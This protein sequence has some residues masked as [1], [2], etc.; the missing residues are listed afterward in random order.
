MNK[1]PR[2]FRKQNRR[3]GIVLI[4]FCIAFLFVFMP[5]C[6]ALIQYGIIIQTTLAMNNISRE[7]GRFASIKSLSATDDSALKTYIK[8]NAAGM[9]ITIKDTD[10]TVTPVPNAVT[11]NS[12]VQYAPITIVVSYSLDQKSFLKSPFTAVTRIPVFRSNYSTQVVMVMQ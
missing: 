5:L 8:S 6:L 12:R 11:P 10:I 1:S 7:A 4:E 3:S 2:N 9:G